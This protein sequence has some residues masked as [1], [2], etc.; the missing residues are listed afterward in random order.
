MKRNHDVCERCE[1][2]V[3]RYPYQ[4]G[5]A[6]MTQSCVKDDNCGGCP[7][8]TEVPKECPFLTEQTVSQEKP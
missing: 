3:D 7:A 5:L 6:C 4:C 8:R 2:Q 1:R